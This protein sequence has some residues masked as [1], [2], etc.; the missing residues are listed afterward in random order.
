MKSVP[1]QLRWPVQHLFLVNSALVSHR[2]PPDISIQKH[3]KATATA[4]PGWIASPSFLQVGWP[5]KEPN[6][7]C[8]WFCP[9]VGACSAGI[10]CLNFWLSDD[11]VHI[12][13]FIGKMISAMSFVVKIAFRISGTHYNSFVC[14]IHWLLFAGTIKTLV[15]AA[16]PRAS[17]NT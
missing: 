1:L 2:A 15:P 5:E 13:V 3:T 14:L 6:F 16:T 10:E 11:Q 17:E 7:Y 9:G 8:E 4:V 12:A